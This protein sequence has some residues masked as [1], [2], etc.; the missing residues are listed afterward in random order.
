ML[1]R[2]FPSSTIQLM[3]A[4]KAL[5]R[6]LKTKAR[7]PKY[8]LIYQHPM[9]KQAGK[10]RGKMARFLSGKISIAAKADYFGKNGKAT[11]EKLKKELEERLRELR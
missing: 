7:P 1:F 2:S 3:G 10:N 8:G 5:F 6:H 11:G 9:I 4:E